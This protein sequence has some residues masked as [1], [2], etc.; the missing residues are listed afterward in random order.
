MRKGQSKEGTLSKIKTTRLVLSRTRK[1]NDSRGE[2]SI[3]SYEELA[4][5]E[6]QTLSL[7]RLTC[8]G[9]TVLPLVRLACDSVFC[10]DLHY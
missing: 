7:V 10:E 3:R 9:A 1:E 4:S 6:F 2:A 5:P 8:S